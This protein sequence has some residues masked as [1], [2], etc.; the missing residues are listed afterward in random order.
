MTGFAGVGP[1]ATDDWNELDVNG[2]Q[3]LRKTAP[4]FHNSSA[5]TLEE[6]VDHYIAFY[7]RVE[8]VAPT[9]VV[10]PVASTDGVHFDRI[11]LPEERA[12]LRYSGE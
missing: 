6:V 4:Y 8:A 1:P 10:P 11:P 9:G 7:K 5:D 12:A 3:G 2:L